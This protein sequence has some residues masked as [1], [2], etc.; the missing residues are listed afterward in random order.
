MRVDGEALVIR[1]ADDGAGIDWEKLRERA[2]ERQLPAETRA[3]LLDVL[4]HDG[5][6][7]VDRATEVSGRGLGMAAVKQ[8]C[9]ALGGR[10]ALN[11]TRGQGTEFRFVFALER[12]LDD[13][14]LEHLRSATRVSA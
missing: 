14:C 6:T 1:V 8:A 2:R 4:C 12:V 5:I 11:S 9:A 13:D 10:I 3:Q 7:T